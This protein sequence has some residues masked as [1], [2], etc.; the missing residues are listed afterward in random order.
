ME[1]ERVIPIVGKDGLRGTIEPDEQSASSDMSQVLVRFDDGQAVLVPVD[2]LVPQ[3]DGS[4]YL[5]LSRADIERQRSA[6][7]VQADAAVVIPVIAEE[8]DIQKRQIE[9]GKV[10]V[11]KLVHEQEEVVDEPLLREVVDVEHVPLNRFVSSPVE[12]R[13]EGETMIIPVLEEVLVVEKRLRLKEEVRITKRRST[14][15]Q[16]EHVTLRSEEAIV[17]RQEGLADSDSGTSL[18]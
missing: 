3:D 13:Y 12:V 14:T 16:P 10:R 7:D 5:P 1:Q 15:H 8:L 2:A 4:Y 17:E 11:R 6:Q 18:A 9:T